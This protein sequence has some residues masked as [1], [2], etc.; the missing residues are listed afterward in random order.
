[1]PPVIR[2]KYL[3]P[4]EARMQLSQ[5]PAASPGDRV[6]RMPLQTYP[7]DLPQIQTSLPLGLLPEAFVTEYGMR[8]LSAIY[9]HAAQRA[10]LTIAVAQK[11]KEA[12]NIDGTLSPEQDQWFTERAREYLDDVLTIT[13]EAGMKMIELLDDQD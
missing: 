8:E 11:I 5:S 1:M 2:R 6:Q 4:D 9:Q 13:D 12:F 7:P 3:V 10:A